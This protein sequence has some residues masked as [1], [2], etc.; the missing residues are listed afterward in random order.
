MQIINLRSG[1]K[2]HAKVLH[3]QIQTTL[4]KILNEKYMNEFLVLEIWGFI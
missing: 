2:S 1:E 4:Y 3:L